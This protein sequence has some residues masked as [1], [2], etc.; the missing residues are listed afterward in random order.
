MNRIT[1][2]ADAEII[3]AAREVIPVPILDLLNGTDW[4]TSVDPIYAGLHTFE[5]TDDGRSYRGTA[6]TAYPFH[7]FDGST[8]IVLPGNRGILTAVHEMGHAL[9][10]VLGFEWDTVPVSEYGETNR[11]EAFA[12]SFVAWLFY[13][14][15][16]DALARDAGTVALFERLAAD[17]SP[18][19]AGL[20]Q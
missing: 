5:D 15:D 12:E 7:T 2:N 16:Q 20:L 4:L 17:E 13:E 18:F 6:H 10:Y 9:D 14:N 3:A 19:V 8:T 11:Y 1:C